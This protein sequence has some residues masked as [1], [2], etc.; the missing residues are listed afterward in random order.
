M[1]DA[2]RPDPDKIADAVSGKPFDKRERLSPP[3]LTIA[4]GAGIVLALGAAH[5]SDD[6]Q[7]RAL[8]AQPP[9]ELSVAYLEAWLRIEPGAP[10]YLDL[11]GQQYL[12]LG[13]WDDA[14]A[15]AKTLRGM[16]DEQDRR[17][18]ILLAL[19]AT[20][21]RA[22]EV[23]ADDPRRAER[24]ARYVEWLDATSQ[25]Q[26]D[27][28]TLR[29]LAEKARLAGAQNLMLRDYRLLAAA[30]AKN[31]AQWQ[32]K[33]ADAA[34]AHAAYDDAANAYFAAQDAA[35]T[36]DD[37]RRLFLAG[38]RVL[39]SANQIARACTEGEKRVGDLANDPATLRYLLD[40]ARQAGRPD[41]MTKYA[42]ALTQLSSLVP[43]ARGAHVQLAGWLPGVS[44]DGRGLDGA[45]RAH[46]RYLDGPDG[47]RARQQ[48]GAYRIVRVADIGLA[49]G[50]SAADAASDTSTKSTSADKSS[51]PST[52]E[53]SGKFD[54][55]AGAASAKPATAGADANSVTAG[56]YDVAFKAFVEAR[57]LDDAER[58]AQQALQRKLDP[59]IWT[60]RLAQ[61]A[62]WNGH[63][64]VALTYWRKY[65]EATGNAEAWQNVYQ[66]APQL[67]D[68][69]AYLAAQI[70][71]A[72]RQPN[73][74]KLKDD[75]VNTYERLGR[76]DDGLA[77]LKRHAAGSQ[78]RALLEREGDVAQ[79][80]GKDAEALATF[81][82]LQKEFGPSPDYALRI[83]SLMYQK[84]QVKPAL[85]EL[86][87]VRDIAGTLPADA[88]YWRTYAEVARLAQSDEDANYA[89]PRLLRTGKAEAIDLNAMTY[90]YQGYPLDAGRTAEAEFRQNDSDLALQSAIYYYTTARAYDRVQALLDGLDAEQRDRF[91]KSSELLATRATY[92]QQIQRWDAALADLR[93]ASRLG[94]A[95]D[96]VRVAYLWALVDYGSDDALAMALH[97]YRPIVAGNADYWGAYGA[98]LL[99]LGNPREAL[100][101]LRQQ[102]SLSDDD[103]LWML[104]LADAEEAAGDAQTA[105]RIRR[106]AWRDLQARAQ[107]GKL[108]I[109]PRRR[110]GAVV[111]R[112]AAQTSDND[113]VLEAQ[114]ARV[115]LAQVFSNGD[116]SRRLLANLLRDDRRSADSAKVGDS[117]LGES[118]ELAPLKPAGD[119]TDTPATR[120]PALLSRPAVISATTRDVGLAWALSGEHFDL[121][122]AWLARE[123]TNRLLRPAD[124][125]IALA[126]EAN[127]RDKMA[128]LLDHRQGRMPIENEVEANERL[129][130][131][132][133]AE[134]LAWRAADG[135]PNNDAVHTTFTDTIL[136]DRSNAGFDLFYSRQAPLSY[137][138]SSLIG[139]LN[140]TSRIGV[141]VEAIQRNQRTIDT[142]QLAWVPAHDRIFNF[143]VRDRTVERD[144]ALTVGHRSELNSFFTG[145]ASAAFNRNTPLTTTFQAGYN[146]FTDI[147][148]NTQVAGTRDFG[149]MQMLWAGDGRW[150][151]Q[152]TAEYDRFHA[153]DRTYLGRGWRFGGELGYKLRIDYPDVNVRL[154]VERGIYTPGTATIPSLAVLLPAGTVPVA[155]EFMPITTTQYGVMTGFGQ[156]YQNAY[157][158]AWRPY[159]DVGYIHDSQQ[160]WGPQVN[161]GMAGSV[162]GNDHARVYYSHDITNGTGVATTQ[163]GVA[164]RLFY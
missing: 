42:R 39:V 145:L 124:A 164:Y 47:V 92:Y 132:T 140:L 134:T 102:A 113:G 52:P 125:E 6:D 111:Q 2:A 152:A 108:R 23:P 17:R 12:G 99:R 31:A 118:A 85:A 127:D 87:K 130:R 115:T 156:D 129:G 142:S 141:T 68:D 53:A 157:R 160:G 119:A 146:Q 27:V 16:S 38:I 30:D 75:I 5:P 98:G 77:Y 79:R 18:G 94:N 57:Q 133:Q 56:D 70:F 82:T 14:M 90:F 21:Q 22:Y 46:L 148:P 114:A 158:R 147:A 83:A 163:V 93:A 62:Q 91:A 96:E 65:A 59:L 71:E 15:I 9:S 63:P 150:Y 1:S 10:R 28:P 51:K 55:E 69:Q 13:R 149:S 60:R 74:L 107:T 84:G 44:A 49:R 50:A 45:G 67:N 159:L 135:A 81:E 95:G 139:S 32:E 137:L 78:R 4:I 58:L 54:W 29:M 131:S 128:Q 48:M 25:Y 19:A 106:G 88:R 73:D 120:D 104:S 3:W 121:A 155:S 80:V 117:L 97:D 154:V 72:E 138:E 109:A 112:L 89:Y 162:L 24:M 123:Y 20:E 35:T 126:L 153:Q 116:T 143:T 7:T 86:R 103:P 110:Q 144:L 34:F 40:V 161:V 136:R 36:R 33:L 122:R 66:L 61:V 105:W 8:A 26:W 41:L 101:Y 11:L 151:G 64:S 43:P 76:P 100:T 37:R